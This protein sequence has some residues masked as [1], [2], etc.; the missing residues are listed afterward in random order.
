VGTPV[1]LYK[2]PANAFVASF[3]GTSNMLDAVCKRDGCGH[4]IVIGD[5]LRVPMNNL[6]SDTEDGAHVRAGVRPEE[7]ILARTGIAGAIKSRVYLGRYIN[8]SVVLE[9]G[10]LV[11]VSQDSAEMEYP[12]YGGD[13]VKLGVDAA[14][15][16]VFDAA[17]RS[18]I[19]G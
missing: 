1:A 3:V 5:K 16:N 17:G 15:I 13:A 12:L 2:R 7:F 6:K 4:A 14:R 8:Y 9:N 19:K 10:E 11:E 18:L